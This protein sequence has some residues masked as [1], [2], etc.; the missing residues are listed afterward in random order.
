MIKSLSNIQKSIL[1]QSIN[2]ESLFSELF[3]YF[4]V[5]QK[6]LFCKNIDM[7]I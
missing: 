2:L 4:D 1:Q 3:N 7:V 6:I 5:K